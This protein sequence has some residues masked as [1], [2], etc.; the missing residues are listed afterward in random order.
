MGHMAHDGNESVVVIGV[1]RQ[2]VFTDSDT[3]YIF[4]GGTLN[5]FDPQY[6]SVPRLAEPAPNA[7]KWS[8]RGR[9]HPMLARAPGRGLGL[10]ASLI[11]RL[12]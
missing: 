5:A 6:V 11:E 7:A 1:Q 10:A 2:D 4:N 12:D 8:A 3:A 9:W